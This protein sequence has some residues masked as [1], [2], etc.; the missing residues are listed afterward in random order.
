MSVAADGP[1]PLGGHQSGGTR[2]DPQPLHVS[3]CI[4]VQA[5]YLMGTWGE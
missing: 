5:E 2:E 4:T 1:G 3:V